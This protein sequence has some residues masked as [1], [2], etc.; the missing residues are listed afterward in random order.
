MQLGRS[1]AASAPGCR[2]PDTHRVC[3]MAPG[4]ALPSLHALPSC[5]P[6]CMPFPP[7]RPCTRLPGGPGAAAVQ[8]PHLGDGREQG[9]LGLLGQAV[10]HAAGARD[11]QRAHRR[12]DGRLR[13]ARAQRVY[14]LLQEDRRRQACERGLRSAEQRARRCC[15]R[16]GA[17]T[18]DPERARPRCCPAGPRCDGRSCEGHGRPRR[19]PADLETTIMPSAA[20]RRQYSC[21]SD[22]ASRSR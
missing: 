22:T 1:T 11:E 6:P 5:H 19:P 8:A 9:P 2:P 4:S 13:G 7:M 14:G 15:R 18:S 20:P 3:C 12:V 10:Q 21:G 17:A 16:R